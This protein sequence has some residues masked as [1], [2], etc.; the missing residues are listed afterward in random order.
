MDRERNFWVIGGDTRQLRLA[1]LLENDG[2]TVHTAALERGRQKEEEPFRDALLA[3]CIIL[4]L[5][6]TTP[7]G[8]LHTP[9]CGGVY[10]LDEVLNALRPG[11]IVCGGMPSA[12]TKKQIEAHGLRFFDYYAR[13]ECMIA[14]AV[15]TAEGAVQIALETMPVTLHES[16][17]LV[18]GYGRVGKLT[19]HR[20]RSLGAR[21]TV[22]ARQCDDLAWARAYG[23][24]T[25]DSRRMS[26]WLGGYDLIVNTVP[27]RILDARHLQWVQPQVL[28]LDLASYPGGAGNGGGRR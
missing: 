12:E 18:I 19:A 27:A 13:E 1:E 8:L 11:Q 7:E 22:A 21:V 26:F 9:L 20:M 5:P 24:E 17:V 2:H 4:P 10:P 6:V 15:P 25:E 28:I 16:R 3:H 14:N 23:Y